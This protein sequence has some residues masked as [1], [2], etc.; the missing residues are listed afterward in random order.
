MYMEE[1]AQ[2][3]ADSTQTMKLKDIIKGV[4]VKKNTRNGWRRCESYTRNGWRRCESYTR[5]GGEDV[6][7]HSK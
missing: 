3:V 1:V 7:V 2:A 4:E 6:K 5:N